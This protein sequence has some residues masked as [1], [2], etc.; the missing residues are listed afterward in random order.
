[1]ANFFRRIGKKDNKK[2]KGEGVSSVLHEIYSKNG[3]GLEPIESVLKGA[4]ITKE[5]N[6]NSN[7][8]EAFKSKMDKITDEL[9]KELEENEKETSSFEKTLNSVK[10]DEEIN[11]EYKNDIND[12]KQEGKQ[13]EKDVKEL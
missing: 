6:I 9:K 13:Q 2:I 8:S 1:M 10:T 3:I 12:S 5:D 4:G 11:N 7:I